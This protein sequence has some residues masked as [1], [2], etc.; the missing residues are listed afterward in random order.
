M[1]FDMTKGAMHLLDM[2]LPRQNNKLSLLSQRYKWLRFSLQGIGFVDL[3]RLW[4]D[5]CLSA[6]KMPRSCISS[7]FSA[8]R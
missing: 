4:A 6:K 2:L 5:T 3:H 7:C 8:R 1:I